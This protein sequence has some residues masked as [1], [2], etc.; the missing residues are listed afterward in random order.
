MFIETKTNYYKL[1]RF[2]RDWS[3]DVY[4]LPHSSTQPDHKIISNENEKNTNNKKSENEKLEQ[5]KT[6]ISIEKPENFH[7]NDQSYWKVYNP[8][9][10]LLR[11]YLLPLPFCLSFAFSQ[12]NIESIFFKLAH[13]LRCNSNRTYYFMEKKTRAKK[14]KLT[15]IE[16]FHLLCFCV[17]RWTMK[18]RRKEEEKKNISTTALFINQCDYGKSNWWISMN[19][20]KIQGK[21]GTNYTPH[22]ERTHRPDRTPYTLFFQFYYFYLLQ[23]R[24][25]YL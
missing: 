20:N 15:T 23:S 8:N 18:E 7:F 21:H 22:I 17:V 6:N 19:R 10:L 3:Q 25:R 1:T 4:F 24:R 16:D 14:K 11:S 12:V 13:E 2:D 9:L 5:K